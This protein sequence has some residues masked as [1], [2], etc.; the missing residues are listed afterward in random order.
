MFDRTT[1]YRAYLE[2]TV[3]FLVTELGEA[4]QAALCLG[5]GLGKESARTGVHSAG[6]SFSEIPNFSLPTVQ[7][8]DGRIY[9][10][11]C[12]RG[13]YCRVEGR[14]HLYEGHSIHEVVFP[15]R[16]LAFWGVKEFVLTNAAG[17]ITENLLPGDLMVIS[18]HLNLL[19]ENPLVGMAGHPF[20]QL[21]P[22]MSRPYSSAMMQFAEQGALDLGVELK[23]GVY[24]A[25]RGPS[26]ETRA[27][28]EML[29]ILGADAVGM[30]TVPEVIALRQMGRSIFGLSL[31]TNRAAGLR[32]GGL[33]HEE[34]IRVAQRSAEM[35]AALGVAVIEQGQQK[36]SG[37]PA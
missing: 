25:V 36:P 22:D 37:W 10:E 29:R 2:E 31:I 32:T 33:S 18:D 13:N 21:F 20:G 26:Y 34:V 35:V 27:E 23:R 5:S 15:V 19:G 6:L 8:H 28:V 17:G 11:K 9:I 1:A 14:L 3:E 16:A 30:S 7:G 4:P 24:A 12:R